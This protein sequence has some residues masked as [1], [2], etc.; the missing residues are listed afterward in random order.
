MGSKASLKNTI[1]S[2]WW[3]AKARKM[4]RTTTIDKVEF[5]CSLLPLEHEKTVIKS[6]KARPDLDTIFARHCRNQDLSKEQRANPSTL[7]VDFK[8]NELWRLLQMPLEYS[9]S[10]WDWN[11]RLP[12]EGGPSEIAAEYHTTVCQAI[13]RIPFSDFVKHAL[14]YTTKARFLENL[15]AAVC[16]IRD[17]LRTE[18]VDRPYIKEIYINVEKALEQRHHPLVHWILASSLQH[19]VIALYDTLAPNLK[20]IQTI[21]ATHDLDLVLT[22]LAALKRRFAY[23]SQ[24]YSRQNWSIDLDFCHCIDEAIWSGKV[25]TPLLRPHLSSEKLRFL[26][27]FENEPQDRARGSWKKMKF[28]MKRSMVRLRNAEG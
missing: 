25:T 22:R 7:T 13:F 14:G 3:E 12:L 15:L 1:A 6:L 28:A 16:D 18:F 17:R 9:E 21:F 10:P 20:P 2:K 5:I 11:W 26:E 27:G 19:P 24:M 8:A 23:G 4:L